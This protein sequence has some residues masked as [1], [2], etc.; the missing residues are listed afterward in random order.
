MF[1]DNYN[2]NIQKNHQ[3][4]PIYMKWLAEFML[5]L[6]NDE[7]S[8]LIQEMMPLVRLG[9]ELDSLLSYIVT[10][11]DTNPRYDAFWDLWLSIREYIF[12]VYEKIADDYRK[13][14]KGVDIG[15]GFED[16]LVSYLLANPYWKE[17]VTEW[18]SL[19]PNNGT[20]YLTA[21]NRLGY[22]PTT[23]YSI[24]RVLYTVG[25]K[26]FIDDGVIWLSEIIN[27]NP[28]LYTK[29]LLENTLFYIEEYIFSYVKKHNADFRIQT[30]YKS[31]ALIVLDFLVARGSTV[32]F[33]LR[34]E[35]I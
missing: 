15:Y 30:N 21:A 32:G 5:N 6:S 8:T 27:G 13:T 26:P 3:L 12:P 9:R 22:N 35:I 31:K 33:L 25:K 17:D 24:A 18:H 7:R 29:P 14:D 19:K 23:L 20:F 2:D 4:E 34:E 11:E 16:V 28:H 1:F 10:A